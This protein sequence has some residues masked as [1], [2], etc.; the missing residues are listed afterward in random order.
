MKIHR[1]KF[2]LEFIKTNNKLLQKKEIQLG[3]TLYLTI[4]CNFFVRDNYN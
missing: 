1:A 4:R 3:D 2:S